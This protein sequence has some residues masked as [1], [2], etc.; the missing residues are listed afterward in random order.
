[1]K[2]LF[3]NLPF[4]YRISRASRWPEKT[5]SGTLYYPYWLAYAAGAAKKA[6]FEVDLIDA[7]ARNWSAEKTAQA[8]LS[9]GADILVAEVSTP[10]VSE[11]IKF[12]SLCRARG[13][14]GRIVV[15]GNHATVFPKELLGEAPAID[16]VAFGEYDYTIVD[17]AG[18]I[19]RP[20]KVAGLAR[21]HAGNVV[22]NEPRPYI[23]NLDE[24]PFVSK[25]YEEYLE[26]GDY[27]YS[28]ARHPM[29]QII[30][31]RGCPFRC[32]FCLSPQTAE[33]RH[34]RARSVE[35]FVGE[36]EYIARRLPQIK[37]VFIEDDT[38]TVDRQRV[39]LICQMILDRGLKLRWSANVRADVDHATLKFMK[40]A[41]CRLVVVGYESGSQAILDRAEKGITLR[42]SLAF[43]AGAKQAG[44]KVF[45]C[46]M[47]GLPGETKQTAGETLAFAEKLD[48]DMVFFQQAVPFPGTKFYQWAKENKYLVSEDFSRWLDEQGRLRTL[49]DYRDLPAAELEAIRDQMMMKYYFSFKY[50]FK[51]LFG[52]RDAG[53]LKRILL[54]AKNYLGYLIGRRLKPGAKHEKV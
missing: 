3:L 46:F 2:I 39:R 4:K 26:F 22:V 42:D 21:R 28:L 54:G 29:V 1:M 38:F 15:A 36:L 50:I 34:Y 11:D 44:L 33:G 47:V 45:G 14:K 51:T 8:L 18:N 13:F 20:E 31:S 48:A 43:A 10:T 35:N 5:K 7:I 24:L 17:L 49:I 16:F 23:D 37:E 32:S 12:F 9:S 52:N 41:G 53:E 25:I 27:F 19:A 30:S 6:G 40:D